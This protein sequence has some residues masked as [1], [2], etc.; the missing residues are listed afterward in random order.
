[1]VSCALK[2]RRKAGRAKEMNAVILS[3]NGYR[4]WMRAYAEEMKED[5]VP[6]SNIERIR[7]RKQ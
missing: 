3:W 7:I 2:Y 1:V 4:K 6:F 5:A